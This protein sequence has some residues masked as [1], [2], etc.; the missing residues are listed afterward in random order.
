M[1]AAITRTSEGRA[2]RVSGA[3]AR[4]NLGGAADGNS[5]LTLAGASPGAALAVGRHVLPVAA[6]AR[7]AVTTGPVLR[8][9]DQDGVAV[10]RL[11]PA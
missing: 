6:V 10:R 1:R 8:Q 9:V 2:G 7:I 4:V 3:F 5:R 11:A